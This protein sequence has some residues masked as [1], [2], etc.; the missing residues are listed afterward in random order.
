ML[1]VYFESLFALLYPKIPVFNHCSWK[2]PYLAF[3]VSVCSERFYESKPTAC[4]QCSKPNLNFAPE[5]GICHS[6]KHFLMG[7]FC[8]S[9]CDG[10]SII[11]VFLLSNNL[12]RAAFNLRF[13]LIFPF[14]SP[15]G[16]L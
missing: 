8:L 3:L 15:M 7:A 14:L 12:L 11:S 5:S 10:N 16:S 9:K 2:L 4:V 1:L 13:C 6:S